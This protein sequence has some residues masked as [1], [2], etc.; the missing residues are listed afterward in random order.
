MSQFTEDLLEHAID[1]FT[2]FDDS[3]WPT[4]T[5]YVLVERIDTQC[6]IDSC[7]QVVYGNRLIG[8]VISGGVGGAE[9]LT[10]LYSS[11]G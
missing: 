5:T 3:N 1:D 4:D 11:A 10:A 2:I 9:Y 7:Q 8:N 6:I